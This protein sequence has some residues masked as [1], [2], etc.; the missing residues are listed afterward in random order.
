[1][2][3][4]NLCHMD[5]SPDPRRAETS[6]EFS[7][8][9]KV[10]NRKENPQIGWL[11]KIFYFGQIPSMESMG[12]AFFLPGDVGDVEIFWGLKNPKKTRSRFQ[13]TTGVRYL[14][15]VN[16]YGKCR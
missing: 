6:A 7:G 14:Y 4:K 13:I 5:R 11:V 9:Q 8:H 15:F 10:A 2:P 3:L 16:F 1:M 12:S